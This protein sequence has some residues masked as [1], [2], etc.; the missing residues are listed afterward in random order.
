MNKKE[1]KIKEI[2]LV[3]LN[4]FY[5]KLISNKE[6]NNKDNEQTNNRK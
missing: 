3:K 6:K 4:K 5:L 2:N 1:Y